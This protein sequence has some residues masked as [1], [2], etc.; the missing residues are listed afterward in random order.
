MGAWA[1]V[2][3]VVSLLRRARCWA[4]PRA[5]AHVQQ[6]LRARA[7][8]FGLTRGERTAYGSGG[9]SRSAVRGP[10]LASRR[11]CCACA[12]S[13]WTG[14]TFIFGIYRNFDLLYRLCTAGAPWCCA[15]PMVSPQTR[16]T[17]FPQSI[18]TRHC[19]WPQS[20][21]AS[22]SRWR[23]TRLPTAGADAPTIPQPLSH[24][25]GHAHGSGRASP[26][27]SA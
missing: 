25:R 1:G 20:S 7:S 19:H 12:L 6:V 26:R 27:V 2:G 4:S 16:E 14:H 9:W 8:T 21:R 18:L 15:I 23:P 22:P 13:L 24:A 17:H 10:G 11:C 3:G 5:C